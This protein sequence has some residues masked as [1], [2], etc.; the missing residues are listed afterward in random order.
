[1]P[2]YFLSPH[3]FACE[4]GGH[5]VFLDLR[6]NKYTAVVPADVGALRAEVSGWRQLLESPAHDD[7]STQTLAHE[8]TRNGAASDEVLI[9]LLREGLLTVDHWRG[10]EATVAQIEPATETLCGATLSTPPLCPHHLRNFICAWLQAT[11]MLRTLPLRLIIRRALRRR[12]RC[13]HTRIT[14]IDQAKQLTAVFLLL[15]PAFYSAADAC[16]RHSVTLIEFLARYRIY[17]TW[18]LGVRMQPFRAHSWVQ[19]GSLAL[20]DPIEH[21]SAFTP[22]LVI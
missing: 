15:Q 5:A 20:L 19:C 21:V 14:E 9:E 11:M 6:Q 18:A 13:A 8:H 17:P 4:V 16:L 3:S 12:A 7:A 10:K 2:R 1:M 22:I